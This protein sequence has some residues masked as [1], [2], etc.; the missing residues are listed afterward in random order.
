MAAVG[1]LKTRALRPESQIRP[2]KVFKTEGFEILTNRIVR[3]HITRQYCQPEHPVIMNEN[4]LIHESELLLKKHLS[5]TEEEWGN[6]SFSLR[7]CAIIVHLRELMK[8]RI[9]AHVETQDL[10]DE[11]AEASVKTILEEDFER[12]FPESWMNG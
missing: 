8:D 4:R 5:S 11:V 10:D 12:I 9:R 3:L 2:E 6:F 7:K 1:N